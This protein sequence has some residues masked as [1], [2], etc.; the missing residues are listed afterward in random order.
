MIRGT[1]TRNIQRPQRSLLGGQPITIIKITNTQIRWASEKKKKFKTPPAVEK[2]LTFFFPREADTNLD[3]KV[4]GQEAVDFIQK[5]TEKRLMSSWEQRYGGDGYRFPDYIEKWGRKPFY[6]VG[7]VFLGGSVFCSFMTNTMCWGALL[8]TA[9]YWGVGLRDIAQTKST[10]R[11]NFPFIGNV[12]YIL[13]SF[14]PEI[15]QYFIESDHEEQPFSRN[16]RSIVYKRAKG[17][18]DS[19]AFGTRK[20]V[21]APNYMWLQHSIFKTSHCDPKDSRTIVGVGDITYSASLLNIS[22]M[23]YGALSNAAVK[24]LNFGAKKGNFYHNTGEGGVSDWHKSAGADIVWNIG[25]GYFGCR[26]METGKFSEE[27]FMETINNTPQIKM[28]EIKL[29]QGAKPGH[30]GLLPAEKVTE[31]IARIRGVKMGENCNSP[32]L[33]S[34][35]NGPYEL[36]AFASRLRELSGRPVG[37][38]LC[39]GNR[40]EVA[41]LVKALIDNPV[42][43]ITVDG[44]EGG[45]GA[46]PFEFS[47]RV[48]T[49]LE[50]GIILMDDL[51]RGAGIRDRIKIIGSGKIASAFG[52]IKTLVYGADFC[53]AAR[54]MMF[55]MGCIQALK[56]DTNKCPTGIA[57]QDPALISGLNYLD[58]GERVY[59]FQKSTVEA[60]CHLIGA[61]GLEGPGRVDRRHIVIP[62][63]EIGAGGCQNFAEVHP[64]VEHGCLLNGTGPKELQHIW[65]NCEKVTGFMKN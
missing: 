61:L 36:A 24:A 65:D 39:V 58:K 22:G 7:V 32:P 30:G 4:D 5:T 2:V 3:G 52:I 28:I 55:A 19:Q 13:E 64:M 26:D 9:F 53:N 42:D 46:A 59:N 47:N 57:T 15:R 16:N 63:R 20:D 10:I 37:I 23:S 31:E 41:T 17:I 60:A 56:C 48:G 49:P 51:L 34:T 38:K 12:R 43:F 40:S 25:T 21:Y 44:G 45:T 62:N 18:S 1:L 6:S 8:P 29:S 35:F 50:M 14:R 11:R 33:H 54:S 27:K